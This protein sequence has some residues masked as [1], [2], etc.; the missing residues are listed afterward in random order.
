MYYYFGF[1][2]LLKLYTL[3]PKI[4]S[5]LSS[6]K[7]L[8]EYEKRSLKSAKILVN[9]TYI[10]IFFVALMTLS[11]IV[12]VIFG[13]SFYEAFKYRAAVPE[14]VD[15]DLIGTSDFGEYRFGLRAILINFIV[16]KP[17]FGQGL[18]ETYFNS[19]ESHK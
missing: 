14:A 17:L 3:Y 7:K 5:T 13:E 16:C 1:L 18:L 15:L 4:S 10:S 19:N 6:E 12:S 11:G 2:V 9:I 8:E